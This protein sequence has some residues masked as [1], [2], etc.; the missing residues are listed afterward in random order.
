VL[1]NTAF[2]LT[3]LAFADASLVIPFAGLH[4]FMGVCF[5]RCINGE[6][7]SPLE[8]FGASLILLGVLT[9]AMS[10]NKDEEPSFTLDQLIFFVQRPLFLGWA[11]AHCAE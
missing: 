9:V 3:A 8:G 4:I 10:A 2:V 7:I 1:L 6:L 5:A 11:G